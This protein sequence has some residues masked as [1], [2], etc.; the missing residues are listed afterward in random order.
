MDIIQKTI[1]SFFAQYGVSDPELK[2]KI[3]PEVTDLI[4]DYNMHVVKWEKETD[5]YH[6]KQIL[7]GI[8]ELEKKIS[9]VFEE[10]ANKN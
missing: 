10:M 2:V 8:E 5:E 4:Y 6:K 9:E 3:L 7:T 1:E